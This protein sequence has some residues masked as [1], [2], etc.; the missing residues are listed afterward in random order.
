MSSGAIIGTVINF[1]MVGFVCEPIA[2]LI[3]VL[4]VASNPYALS[5]DAINTMTYLMMILAAFPFIYLIALLIHHIIMEYNE[6]S[7]TV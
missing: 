7:G 1:F 2:L 4:I 6:S 3:N 5:A